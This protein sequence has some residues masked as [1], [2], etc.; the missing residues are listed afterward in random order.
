MPLNTYGA[1]RHILDSKDALDMPAGAQEGGCASPASS[2]WLGSWAVSDPFDISTGLKNRP[3]WKSFCVLEPPH[4][5]TRIIH[6]HLNIYHIYTYVWPFFSQVTSLGSPKPWEAH[7]WWGPFLVL[8]LSGV[9]RPKR[10]SIF[11]TIGLLIK[12]LTSSVVSCSWPFRFRSVCIR[13]R[14]FSRV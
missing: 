13:C 5:H 8:A 2:W 14:D 7:T 3:P 4:T 1:N 6:L 10:S 11:Q 12:S 9:V